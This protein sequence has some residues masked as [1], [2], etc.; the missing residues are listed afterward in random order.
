VDARLDL[1]L[2]PRRRWQLIAAIVAGI[3]VI[4]PIALIEGAFGPKFYEW[5]YELHPFRWDGVERYVGFRPLGFFEDGNQYGIWVTATALAGIWLWH[6][7][8]NSRLRDRL[9][10]VAG[11]GLAIALV[12]QSVGAILLLCAGL[13]LCW[14]IGRSLN[15][16]VLASSV[17]PMVLAG[18]IYF[19]GAVPLRALAEKTVIGQQIV[20]V[21]RAA[22][23]GSFIWRMARDQRALT[24][25]SEHPV[26]GAG[27]WDWWRPNGERP[28]GL[29]LMIVGQFGVVG[30]VLAFGSLLMPA[31]RALKRHWYASAWHQPAVPLAVIVLMAIADAMLDSFFF[32]TPIHR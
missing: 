31:I 18:T 26:I 32:Y 22:G 2:R 15:R 30:M 14:A 12:S 4:L 27:R 6:T 25:I 5:F 11:L 20:D 23:R 21:F 1:F 7:A 9:A 19:S 8:P 17:A 3:A 13:A 16:W 29:L 28:W 10:V 24:L